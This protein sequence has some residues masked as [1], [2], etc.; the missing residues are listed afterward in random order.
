MENKIPNK[1]KVFYG[2]AGLGQNMVYTLQSFFLFYYF[3]VVYGIDEV[4]VGSIFLIARVWDAVNDFIMGV[5]VDNTKTRWGKLRPYLLFT[6]LPIAVCTVL[7]FLG[8]DL[9]Y[10]LKVIYVAVAYILWGMIYTICDVP[11]WGLSSAMSNDTDERT[12]LISFTKIMTMVGSGLAIAVIPIL[13]KSFGGGTDTDPRSYLIVSIIV[14]TIGCGLL[15]LAFFGTKERVKVSNDKKNAFGNI[16]L[17]FKNVPLLIILFSSIL[18]FTRFMSQSAGQYVANYILGDGIYVSILG[19]ILILSMICAMLLTP[20]LTKNHTKKNVYIMTSFIG[21]IIYFL[22]YL[23][24]YH[25]LTIIIFFVFVSSLSM[26]FF[27][28]LQTSMIADSVDYLEWKTGK[29]AEGICFSG[30]TFFYKLDAA[31][32]AYAMGWILKFSHFDPDVAMTVSMK[33]GVYSLVSLVPGIGCL[34]SIFPMFFYKFT[35]DKQSACI[36]E[37]RERRD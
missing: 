36:K 7:L 26:G 11:Y 29:R 5:I 32:I 3:N 9:I 8:P 13:L 15:S 30:Q 2:M 6:P 35:E 33:N 14:A 34:L 28:V 25:N 21:A 24:G 1:E 31:L 20:L 22:M 10:N 19:G 4:T 27:S 23:F 17:L 12:K 37:I 16:L 18:G